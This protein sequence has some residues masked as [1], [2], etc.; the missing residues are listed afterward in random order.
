M[1]AATLSAAP[2]A[3]VADRRQAMIDSQLRPSDVTAPRVIAAFAAVDREAF[4][5][6]DRAAAAYADRAVPVGQGR[7]LNAPLTTARLITDLNPAPGAKILLIGA[8]TGYA[9]AVL[10]AMGA[11]VVAVE[12]DAALAAAAKSAASA[13]VTIVEGPLSAGAPGHAP[14]DAL[15]VDGAVDSLPPALLAQLA[16]GA[17]IVAGVS[18][19]PVTRL[20]RGVRV[21]GVDN[22]ALLPFADIDCVALPGFAAPR[23]FAF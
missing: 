16:D 2:P 22:V 21:A 7:A 12:E 4:V 10:A 20:A 19:G 5:P 17:R 23:G 9:A 18:D 15:L 1:A 13:G 3:T 14:F 8:V 11:V 6:A